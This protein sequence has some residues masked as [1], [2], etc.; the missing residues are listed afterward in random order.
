MDVDTLELVVALPVK[1]GEP[2]YRSDIDR[3]EAA[4]V[5]RRVTVDDPVRREWTHRDWDDDQSDPEVL[6][7]RGSEGMLAMSHIRKPRFSLASFRRTWPFCSHSQLSSV[8]DSGEVG[9]GNVCPRNRV[10]HLE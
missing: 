2:G 1:E 8:V 3:P 9:T 6:G 4:R 5:S 7:G 10:Y